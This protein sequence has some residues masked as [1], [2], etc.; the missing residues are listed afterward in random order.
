MVL[1]N[2]TVASTSACR[3]LIHWTVI[4]VETELTFTGLFQKIAAGAHPRLVVEEELSHSRLDK[5]Y[6]GTTKDSLSLV[7]EQLVVSGVSSM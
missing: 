5:V 7:D 2:I 4:E 6:V 1:I 3:T